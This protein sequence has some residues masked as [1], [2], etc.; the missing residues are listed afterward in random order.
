MSLSSEAL[1]VGVV[2]ATQVPR[3]GVEVAG[4][5]GTVSLMMEA[6]AATWAFRTGVVLRAVLVSRPCV[7][8]G[9]LAQSG[10]GATAVG[11]AVAVQVSCVGDDVVDV[12]EAAFSTLEA[13]AAA[14]TSR[15]VQRR[16]WQ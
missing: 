16:Q 15:Q 14:W 2:A 10:S 5:W 6:A 3:L 13:A 7:V 9:A 8:L 1:S 12:W 11:A 4:V